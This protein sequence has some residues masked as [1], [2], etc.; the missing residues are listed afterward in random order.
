MYLIVGGFIPRDRHGENPAC[1]A[2]HLYY[3][4]LAQL[5][6]APTRISLGVLAFERL[7]LSGEMQ[8]LPPAPPLWWPRHLLRRDDRDAGGLSKKRSLAMPPCG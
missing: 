4:I 5:G 1:G 7:P 6:S 2:H 3:I 8:L